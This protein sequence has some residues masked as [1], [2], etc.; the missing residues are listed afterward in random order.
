MSDFLSKLDFAGGNV[1]LY[2]VLA[3][4]AIFV[5]RGLVCGFVDSVFSVCTVIVSVIAAVV[6]APFL[7]SVF[8]KTSFAESLEL[9]IEKA[10]R[11]AF[12]EKEDELVEELETDA[13]DISSEITAESGEAESEESASTGFSAL[14]SEA[15]QNVKAEDIMDSLKLPAVIQNLI[16][17]RSDIEEGVKASLD[18]V[19]EKIAVSLTHILSSILAF[20]IIFI[21]VRIVLAIIAGA[22]DLV[23]KLPVVDTLNHIGGGL[24]GLGYGLVVVWIVFTAVALFTGT[25]IGSRIYGMISE[26]TILTMLYNFNPLMKFIG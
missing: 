10:C 11:V 20:V 24:V 14:I 4:L 19:S 13:S 23:A 1:V 6:L 3:I 2:I 8:E 21:A 26:N 15:A 25:D 16:K 9:R 12:N 7:S 22:L 17:T 18:T 5:I